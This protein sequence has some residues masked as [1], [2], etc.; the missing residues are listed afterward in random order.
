MIGIDRVPECGS[1]DEVLRAHG[2]DAASLRERLLRDDVPV[3]GHRRHAAHTARAGIF[4][5]EDAT[6]DVLGRRIEMAGMQTAGLT[7]AE[8]AVAL[9]QHHGEATQPRPADCLTSTR[10]ACRRR[11]PAARDTCCRTSARTSKRCPPGTTW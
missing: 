5:W 8:I 6:L 7:D 4:A 11:C 10:G 2:L 9:V 1:N 3:L